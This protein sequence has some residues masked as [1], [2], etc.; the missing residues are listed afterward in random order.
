MLASSARTM[1]VTAL[2]SLRDET[3]VSQDS[4]A[5]PRKRAS[6]VKLFEIPALAANPLD[7]LPPVND[8]FEFKNRRHQTLAAT[9]GRFTSI[10]KFT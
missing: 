5:N 8:R 1:R 7:G 2:F 3:Q 9:S 6:R 10:S 4:R